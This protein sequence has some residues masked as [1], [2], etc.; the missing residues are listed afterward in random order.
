[1]FEDPLVS[2]AEDPI[3]RVI[4]VQRSSQRADTDKLV[5]SY[6]KAMGHMQTTH[7]GWSMIL[8]MR[9]APGN[10]SDDFEE[11][12]AKLRSQLRKAFPRVVVLVATSVGELQV[13]RMGRERHEETLVTTDE[14]QARYWVRQR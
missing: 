8:D 12:T 9:K 2:V 13:K 1:M 3:E 5:E 6:V 10:N 14:A 4:W 11:S 7:E